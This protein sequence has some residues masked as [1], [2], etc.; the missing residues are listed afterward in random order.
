MTWSYSFNVP[1]LVLVQRIFARGLDAF[2]GRPH[3]SYDFVLTVF[4]HIFEMLFEV[5]RKE[6]C[7]QFSLRMELRVF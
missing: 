5:T 3:N 1:F 4:T 7:K 2:R 6:I